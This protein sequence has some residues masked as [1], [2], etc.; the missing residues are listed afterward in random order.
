MKKRIL[1][2]L[3]TVSI[4]VGNGEFVYAVES[5]S[6]NTRTEQESTVESK[7]EDIS[8][9]I[10]AEITNDTENEEKETELE[11]SEPV[12]EQ[13]TENPQSADENVD[14][15]NEFSGKCG[16]NAQWT[17]DQETKELRIS[18]SGAMSDYE[19]NEDVPWKTWKRELKSIVVEEGIS[20]IGK[21]H[22]VT[23]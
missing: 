6:G 23:V 17:Y 9:D 21:M 7:A 4:V 5:G 16:E 13:S 1:A 12:E 8:E 18:G 15:S 14:K 2:L 10:S 19:S 22:F 11:E 3:L 20:T